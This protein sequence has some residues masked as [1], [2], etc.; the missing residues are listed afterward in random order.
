MDDVKLGGKKREREDVEDGVTLPS[1]NS[2]QAM[3]TTWGSNKTVR[4]TMFVL[5]FASGFVL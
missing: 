5:G 2:R 3:T 1:S 4:I